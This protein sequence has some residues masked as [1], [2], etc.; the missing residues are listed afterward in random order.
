MVGMVAAMKG[1]NRNRSKTRN[2]SRGPD[3][4]SAAG[5]K[6]KLNYTAAYFEDFLLVIEPASPARAA[7]MSA[8][9]SACTVAI[10]R[11]DD[12]GTLRRKRIACPAPG[13]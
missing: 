2:L 4:Y 10:C 11:T 5:A 3:D 8:P 6:K 13:R 7:S 1:F 12:D 9:T